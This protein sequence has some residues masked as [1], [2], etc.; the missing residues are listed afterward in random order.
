METGQ[1]H[2]TEESKRKMSLARKGKSPW[3]KGKRGVYSQEAIEQ[4]RLAAMG[5]KMSEETREK[6]RQA[7]S[8]DKHYN[9]KGGRRKANGYIEIRVPNTERGY[10]FEHR[11]VVE[12]HLGRTLFPWET[13]HHKNGIKDDNRIE[14]LELL[15]S[16]K[17]NTRVQKVFQENIQ[18]K[19]RLKKLEKINYFLL[20]GYMK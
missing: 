3:N 2:H 1:F 8:G 16:G 12:K 15:P 7:I 4:M 14:N 13:I 10:M 9:W 19:Q 18:L 6:I 20:I 11:H 5:R 17:H